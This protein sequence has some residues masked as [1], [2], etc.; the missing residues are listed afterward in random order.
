MNI[1]NIHPTTEI[2]IKRLAREISR[3]NGLKHS[4]ALNFAAKSAGFEN[5]VAARRS[6]IKQPKVRSTSTGLYIT[7]YWTELDSGR[8]TIYLD[9]LPHWPQLLARQQ[10]LN[11]RALMDFRGQAPDHLVFKEVAVSQQE[12]IR[13]ICHAV[14]ELQFMHAT[15]LKPVKRAHVS[16]RSFRENRPELPR[17]DH[18][19]A[20][21][22]DSGIKV[23][24]DEPYRLSPDA[25]ELR[26]QWANKYRFTISGV[27]WSVYEPDMISEMYLLSDNTEVIQP[28]AQRINEYTHKPMAVSSWKLPSQAYR[29]LF[30]SPLQVACNSP[31][32]APVSRAMRIATKLTIPMDGFLM[33]DNERRPNGQMLLNVHDDIASRL[34][35]IENIT[36]H[37]SGVRS[38]I[39]RI[40]NALDEW[41]QREYSR[42]ELPHDRFSAMYLPGDNLRVSAKR[43][44]STKE[45]ESVAGSLNHIAKTLSKYYPM[46][47][48][49]KTQLEQLKL[50]AKSLKSWIPTV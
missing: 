9:Y 6:F 44:I 39:R 19:S 31:V 16:F 10:L 37:R 49:L 35:N 28:I 25:H 8:E 50:A 47:A 27:A 15:G 40:K 12:A 20:W 21:K 24:L 45:L 29:P 7:A 13:R 26:N 36:Y 3:K 30:R 2:G 1:A 18:A 43:Q 41:V 5:Y 14:R 23:L 42:I 46:C 4:D 38:R 22:T 17:A 48:P 11:C 34:N 32:R 33:G